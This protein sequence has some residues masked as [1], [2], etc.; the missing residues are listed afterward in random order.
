MTVLIFAK[1]L[2]HIMFVILVLLF[3]KWRCL[4]QVRGL[5]LE[6]LT[7]KVKISDSVPKD[8]RT[9][10]GQKC[11]IKKGLCF[12]SRIFQLLLICGEKSFTLRGSYQFF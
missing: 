7:F 1:F 11:S 10:T 12:S 9:V 8:K 3:V 5:S 2:L 6:Q 4:P